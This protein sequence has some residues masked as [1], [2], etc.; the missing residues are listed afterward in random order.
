MK[1]TDLMEQKMAN[2]AHQMFLYLSK[3][4]VSPENMADELANHLGT[5]NWEYKGNS[6]K[7]VKCKPYGKVLKFVK[8]N[9]LCVDSTP[10][11]ILGIVGEKINKALVQCLR[12]ENPCIYDF[13]FL[14][15]EE[16]EK[17]CISIDCEEGQIMLLLDKSENG[18]IF[19]DW[20]IDRLN[21]L[22]DGK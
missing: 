16:T 10:I 3:Q 12:Y 15:K 17:G 22:R 18:N 6:G 8:P 1:L 2:E 20:V 14:T 5:S 7:T 13:D 19:A 4:N 21:G 9:S 11:A